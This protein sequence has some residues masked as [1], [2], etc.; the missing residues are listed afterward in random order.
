MDWRCDHC[1]FQLTLP[2]GVTFLFCPQCGRRLSE[3]QPERR[4]ARCGESILPDEELHECRFC[5]RLYHHDCWR[6]A[7]R[8][9]N[10]DCPDEDASQDAGGGSSVMCSICG[11]EVAPTDERHVCPDCGLVYHEDCWQENRGCANQGCL[12]LAGDEAPGEEQAP[13]AAPLPPFD[14]PSGSSVMCSICGTEV[15]PTDERHV[16][17]DCG[18][19]YHED[20]W[21]ENQG[22]ATYGCA[23]SSGIDVHAAEGEGNGDA[24]TPE[25]L[26]QDG[27]GVCPHCGVSVNAHSTFCWSCG[28]EYGTPLPQ[29]DGDGQNRQGTSASTAR[30]AFARLIDWSLLAVLYV[31]YVLLFGGTRYIVVFLVFLAIK[32]AFYSLYGNS[33]GK[34]ICGLRVFQQDGQPLTLGNY[35]EREFAVSCACGL[36]GWI[37]ELN[38]LNEGKQT[39]YDEKNGWRVEKSG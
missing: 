29:A 27:V 37:R 19:V 34:L 23:S 10:A 22:C 24:P 20:C 4:C 33:P 39:S 5:G 6:V 7:G 13:A 2:E 16:C 25:N 36:V 35:L 26:S 9:V 31:L 15:A 14:E 18:L 12:S 11:T 38:R 21:Q 28:K 17:P 32:S 1:S 3:R 30:R 8:C